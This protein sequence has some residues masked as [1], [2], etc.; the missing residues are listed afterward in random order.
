MLQD[1]GR[2][3]DQLAVAEHLVAAQVGADVEVLAERGQV[4]IAGRTGREQRAGLWIE[5]AEPHEVGGELGGQDREVA[6]HVARREPR[7]WAVPVAA[8]DRAPG[9]DAGLWN[10]VR[11]VLN[12]LDG[13]RHS[14]L[15]SLATISA[16]VLQ[17]II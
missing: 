15:S 2:L 13:H 1:V 14:L 9:V 4:W 17:H 3:I 6:L 7:G 11:L 10:G 16:P 8:A 5:L 12:G